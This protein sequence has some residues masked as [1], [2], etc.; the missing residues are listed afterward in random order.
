MADEFC[1]ECGYCISCCD[2]DEDEDEDEDEV[3]E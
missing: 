1:D 2:C 3:A